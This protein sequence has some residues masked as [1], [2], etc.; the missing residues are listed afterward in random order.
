M[1]RLRNLIQA[2]RQT[3][4]LNT[5]LI[6]ARKRDIRVPRYV[7]DYM[8]IYNTR[9]GPERM[10]TPEEITTLRAI[11]RSHP[12]ES[13]NPFAPAEMVGALTYQPHGPKRTLVMDLLRQPKI[14]RVVVR[15]SSEGEL[16]SIKNVPRDFRIAPGRIEEISKILDKE[17]QIDAILLTLGGEGEALASRRRAKREV[18]KR[19]PG[20]G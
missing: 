14:P 12:K 16:I 20:I 3:S 7:R 13:I 17:E 9:H 11:I 19:G 15:D 4:Q 10:V 8:R 6:E 5:L 2:H 18:R 1:V